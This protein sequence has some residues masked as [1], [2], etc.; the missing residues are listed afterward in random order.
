M[1]FAHVTDIH[2]EVRPTLGEL[3]NKR[4]L[5]AI[6]LYV[7]GRA[8]HFTQASQRGLVQAVL[9]ASPDVVLCTGDL[10]A[11]GTDAEFLAARELLAPITDRFPFFVISGNHEIGRAHV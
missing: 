11:T 2:V 10:T 8:H 4:L 9:D 1:R 3:G 5:G 6:N 7:L